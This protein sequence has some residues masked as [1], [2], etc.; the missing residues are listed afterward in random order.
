[1]VH[2]LEKKRNMESRQT[3]F[4][5]CFW[6]MDNIV[7]CQLCLW[8]GQNECFGILY[9]GFVLIILDSQDKIC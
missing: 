7:M 8:N 9:N 6:M 1:M 3:L 5:F 4:L 2:T